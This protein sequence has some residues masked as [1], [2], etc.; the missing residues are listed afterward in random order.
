MSPYTDLN[1]RI[2]RSLVIPFDCYF[3]VLLGFLCSVCLVGF[4]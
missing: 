3:I 1:I 2:L 4:Y